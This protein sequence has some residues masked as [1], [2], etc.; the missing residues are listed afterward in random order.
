MVQIVR[1]VAQVVER[2]VWDAEV[3]RSIRVIPT[4]HI[5]RPWYPSRGTAERNRAPVV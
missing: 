1:D 3:A 5:A 4:K 2:G